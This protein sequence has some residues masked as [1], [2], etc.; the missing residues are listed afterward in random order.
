MS[1]GHYCSAW[2]L[3]TLWGTRRCQEYRHHV[4]L[5]R[6]IRNWTLSNSTHSDR[7]GAPNAQYEAVSA[8]GFVFLGDWAAVLRGASPKGLNWMVRSKTDWVCVLGVQWEFHLEKPVMG[9][10]ATCLCS[11]GGICPSTFTY[12]WWMCE[13]ITSQECRNPKSRVNASGLATPLSV[14]P[15]R[16][17]PPLWKHH[18]A[19]GIT[20]LQV[21]NICLRYKHLK[22][23]GSLCTSASLPHSFCCRW[24]H[25]CLF[26]VLFLCV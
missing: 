10:V 22:H 2:F 16:R 21:P 1:F 26:F 11:T 4:H 17:G 6:L 20:C 19:K 23:K 14:W 24:S 13:W 5:S 18:L 3:E 8:A 9:S 25:V 12:R 15:A 7:R